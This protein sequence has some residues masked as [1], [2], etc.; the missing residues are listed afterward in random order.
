[1]PQKGPARVYEPT[2][3][4]RLKSAGGTEAELR[5]WVQVRFI[6]VIPLH[7]DSIVQR[8]LVGL[9]SEPAP[10]RGVSLGLAPGSDKLQHCGARGSRQ[11]WPV[12][13]T[14]GARTQGPRISLHSCPQPYARPGRTAPPAPTGE[15]WSSDWS[16]CPSFHPRAKASEHV[17]SRKSTFTWTHRISTCMRSC[18]FTHEGCHLLLHIR[19]HLPTC[20]WASHSA[21]TRWPFSHSPCW[22]AGSKSN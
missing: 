17:F 2:I 12:S 20:H 3:V 11:A 6:H 21:C 4:P 22:V 8:K 15:P 16:D 14:P 13:S 5:I 9:A 18:D 10:S 19:F 1:M 7:L